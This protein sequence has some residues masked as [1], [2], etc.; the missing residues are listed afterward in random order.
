[1]K[2]KVG[3]IVRCI[4]DET[5]YSVGSKDRRDLQK[6]QLYRVEAHINPL[7]HI[8]GLQY[9]GVYTWRFELVDP[10]DVTEIERII[11]DLN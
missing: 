10:R 8:R 11:F 4:D 3:D 7:V 6:G 9:G 5:G 2:F 1:M